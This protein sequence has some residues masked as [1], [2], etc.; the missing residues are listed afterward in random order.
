[1]KTKR[2]LPFL[3]TALL[4]LSVTHF[5]L[6]GDP[7][8]GWIILSSDSPDAVRAVIT[9]EVEKV[10]GYA[11]MDEGEARN[12]TL[13]EEKEREDSAA[14]AALIELTNRFIQV[15]RTRDTVSS[16]FAEKSSELEDYRKNV[17]TLGM[18]IQNLE[19]QIERS[20]K[21]IATQQEHL[22]KTLRTEKQGE[23]LT[24]VIHTQGLRD[25]LYDLN[26]RAD[27]LSAPELSNLMGT[28]IQSYSEVIGGVLSQD[29]IRSVTEG[30]AKPVNEEPV[31]I[32]LDVTNQGTKYLRVKRYELYPFQESGEMRKAGGAGADK[33]A[34]VIINSIDDLERFLSR[35]GYQ[36]ARYD[37]SR[38]LKLINE[39]NQA[40]RMQNESLK[41]TIAGIQE[42]ITNQ[43]GKI[44]EA[45]G[46]RERDSAKRARVEET[47][48]RLAAELAV[49]KVSKEKAEAELAAVQAR[50]SEMKRVSETIILKFA[51][52]ASKGGQSPAEASIEAII[53]KLDEVKNEA[54]VQHSRESVEVSS[55]QLTALE[56][57]QQSTEA[58][59]TAVRLI[60]FTNEG[61]NGVRV[62][63]A[64]R[65]R[66]VMSE[67]EQIAAVTHKPV[68]P[69]GVKQPK[70]E[71]KKPVVA[72]KETKKGKKGKKAATKPESPE[73]PVTPDKPQPVVTDDQPAVTPPV[74][75][76][77]AEPSPPVDSKTMAPPK[78]MI[79]RLFTSDSSKA[80][81]IP[82]GL[83]SP[84]TTLGQH[85]KDILCVAFSP[86][87][88][89]A[90][91]GDRDNN[92]IVWDARTW[93]PTATLKGHRN[94]VQA[95]AFSPSGRYLAS[96]ADDKAVIIWD[97]TTQKQLRTLTI[98]NCVTSLGFT[99]S[100]SH[101]AVGS[102]SKEICIWDVATGAKSR[103][104]ISG[105]DVLA[106]AYS[107]NGK[108]LATAG[109]EKVVRLWNIA[110]NKEG[111]SLAGH[112]DDIT[113][114]AFTTDGQQLISGGDD[115][116][117]IIWN[118][119]TAAQQKTL[120]GHTE[121][122]VALAVTRDGRRLISVD[123]SRSGGTIIVWDLKSGTIIKR[124]KTQQK[125][126]CMSLSPDG[127]HLL[128]GSDK[129]LLVYG[130]E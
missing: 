115:K 35:N 101:L 116:G 38:I 72:E 39:V 94:N 61:S 71:P 107:P 29:F 74:D 90:A 18:Q 23:A 26:R 2:Y 33:G 46:D 19:S 104:F 47:V 3:C 34:A 43:R 5:A 30:T 63:V 15:K 41:E 40:N 87:G 80:T 88:K 127:R 62:R 114:L 97:L 55:S 22:K 128:V 82:P 64:F 8:N 102:K 76:T 121:K 111:Q 31:R 129:L 75:T 28:S 17:N 112:R 10:T 32:Q 14:K 44:A 45:R 100:G 11:T 59:V 52:Q 108:L 103:S 37:T 120:D 117:I 1:M 79:E 91:S 24:A 6:A 126:K 4:A 49:Q 81:E 118:A 122:V 21:E 124:L 86:D 12:R 51:L 54:R 53:D 89:R 98:D 93:T 105:D 73:K 109:K 96:G 66:T 83:I 7:V 42:R 9:S 56:R 113:A 125:I 27:E 95:L 58:R 85:T 16:R 48:K 60:A 84:E 36:I 78:N 57:E 123:S 13:L 25:K 92:V 67:G 99:S 69:G 106:L 119:A 70:P 110:G 130:L 20:E 68:I 50:L 77:P 65:V